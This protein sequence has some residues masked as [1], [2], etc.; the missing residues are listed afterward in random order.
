MVWGG[1]SVRGKTPLKKIEEI[2]DK[3]RHHKIL[4]RHAIPHGLDILGRGYSGFVFQEDNDR[5]NYVGLIYR[6]G[7]I[8]VKLLQ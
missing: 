3:H 1:I 5:P 8:K 7:K 4:F 2:M 6:K